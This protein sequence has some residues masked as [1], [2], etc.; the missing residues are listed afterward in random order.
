MPKHENTNGR[1]LTA[2]TQP[3]WKTVSRSEF[4]TTNPAAHIQQESQAID[5]GLE[6]LRLLLEQIPA[7]DPTVPAQ[8]GQDLHP[9]AHGWHPNTYLGW[10]DHKSDTSLFI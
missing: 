9:S 3:P 6:L 1:D 10:L 7:Q 5:L 8:G 4:S 2:N